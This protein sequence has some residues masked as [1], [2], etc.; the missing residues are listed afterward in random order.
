MPD[1]DA[2]KK[3]SSSTISPFVQKMM[4]MEKTGEIITTA[5]VK[6]KAAAA[7]AANPPVLPVQ[8]YGPVPPSKFGGNSMTSDEGLKCMWLSYSSILN[9]WVCVF[10]FIF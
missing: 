5:S 6:A 2:K 3:A 7:A 10:L 4:E 8:G 9:K 1:G